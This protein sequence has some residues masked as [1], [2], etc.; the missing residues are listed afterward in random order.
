[1]CAEGNLGWASMISSKSRQFKIR[2]FEWSEFEGQTKLQNMLNK[3]EIF[4]SLGWLKTILREFSGPPDPPDVIRRS[5]VD[6]R[7]LTNSLSLPDCLI[8][9]SRID[10]A[11]R[12]A[13]FAWAGLIRLEWFAWF[14]WA[15]F[16]RL[17]R[18]PDLPEHYWWS[19]SGKSGNQAYNLRYTIY[20]AQLSLN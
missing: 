12:L 19:C 8:C 7:L 6:H 16:I 9:M 15:G 10:Q 2:E 3:F 4:F 17:G 20:C 18:V 5:R 13:W 11:W 1:M 14:S